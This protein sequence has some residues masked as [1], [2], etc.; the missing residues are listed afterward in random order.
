MRGRDPQSLALGKV[1]RGGEDVGQARAAR[2]AVWK[3]GGASAVEV[4]GARQASAPGCGAGPAEPRRRRVL[5]AKG[6]GGRR[7]PAALKFPVGGAAR[8]LQV[9][10]RLS[11]LRSAPR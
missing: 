7:A 1:V 3:P 6:P 10:S 4:W 5:P 11:L 8:A 2:G 9:A